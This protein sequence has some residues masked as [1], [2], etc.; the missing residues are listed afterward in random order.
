MGDCKCVNAKVS[1]SGDVNAKVSCDCE[2]SASVSV[3]TV[4]I[5]DG[6]NDY[7]RL[8][9]LPSIEGTVL[10]GDRTLPQIGVGLITEQD[11]DNI[12]FG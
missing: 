9:H 7:E 12:V 5:R 4:T 8:V 1:V 2:T 10:K 6:T 11:I 3:G